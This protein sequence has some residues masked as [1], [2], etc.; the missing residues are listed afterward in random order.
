ML[1]RFV[2]GL[3]SLAAVG[4]VLLIGVGAALSGSLPSGVQNA[5]AEVAGVV[6]FDVPISGEQDQGGAQVALTDSQ[7]AAGRSDDYVQ[8]VHE[9]IG[10]YTTALDAWTTCVA[11]AAASRGSLQ[12]DPETRVESEKFD[13]TAECDHK[14]KLNL[15]RPAD[16]GLDGPHNGN[17]SPDKPGRP[18]DPVRPDNPGRPDDTGP[19]SERP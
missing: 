13:P 2:T 1:R 10:A 11:E 5:V 15:P 7:D 3:T 4:V 14:P 9:T 8:A 18:D 16:Y 17:T 12:S 19:P 6:G